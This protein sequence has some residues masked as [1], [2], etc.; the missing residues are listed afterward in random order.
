MSGARGLSF[1]LFSH[2]PQRCGVP[3][4]QVV[5]GFTWFSSDTRI[6]N[7]IMLNI[8]LHV[9]LCINEHTSD[10]LHGYSLS[11]AVPCPTPLTTGLC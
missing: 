10:Q 8:R 11:S 3:A 7:I 6:N 5:S 9:V 4:E 2:E 1:T